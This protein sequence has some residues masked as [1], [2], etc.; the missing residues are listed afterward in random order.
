MLVKELRQPYKKWWFVLSGE[1]K[2]NLNLS[3]EARDLLI[4]II[5]RRQNSDSESKDLLDMLM[6]LTYE[7]GSKMNQEQLIDE[8]FNSIYCRPRNYL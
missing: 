6:A 4:G 8:I 5:K 2:R 7:D 1:L 3:Q